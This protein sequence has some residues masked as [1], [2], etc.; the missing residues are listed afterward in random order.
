[1]SKRND[2]Q[3]QIQIADTWQPVSKFVNLNIALE[4]RVWNIDD[5]LGWYNVLTNISPN[6]LLDEFDMTPALRKMLK[7]AANKTIKKCSRDCMYFRKCL[8][9]SV[10]AASVIWHKLKQHDKDLYH[11]FAIMEPGRRREY[12]SRYKDGDRLY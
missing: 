11:H 5:K 8:G 2:T 12:F 4:K 1:M 3:T 9:L 10:K 7:K 6:T